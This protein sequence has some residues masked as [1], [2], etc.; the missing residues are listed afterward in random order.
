MV[1]DFLVFAES[2]AAFEEA[3]DAFEGDRLADSDTYTARGVHAR[4][5]ASSTSTSTSA[6]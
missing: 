5:A 4:P 6:A 1:G 3:V 2:E